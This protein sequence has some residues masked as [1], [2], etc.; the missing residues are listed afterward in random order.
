MR[1]LAPALLAALLIGLT[2]TVSAYAAGDP[3]TEVAWYLKGEGDATFYGSPARIVTLTCRQAARGVSCFLKVKGYRA[4]PV[5]SVGLFR[6]AGFAVEGQWSTPKRC[7]GSR[8]P[9]A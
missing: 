5:C 4:Y 6:V 8:A 2:V 1:L 3:V 9:G 7:G